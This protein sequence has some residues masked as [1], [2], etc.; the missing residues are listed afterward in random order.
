MTE[1]KMAVK[2]D[3]S[4]LD[5]NL[6]SNDWNIGR[7]TGF[8]S[9]IVLIH[10]YVVD[11]FACL[12]PGIFTLLILYIIFVLTSNI[13]LTTIDYDVSKL[14]KLFLFCKEMTIQFAGFEKIICIIIF[15]YI[16]GFLLYRQDPDKPDKISAYY[17]WLNTPDDTR[18]YSMYD[19]IIKN[20]DHYFRKKYEYHG[21]IF[22]M[23]SAFFGAYYFKKVFDLSREEYNEN[24]IKIE[25]PYMKLK[26]FL[27]KNNNRELADFISWKIGDPIYSLYMTKNFVNKIKIILFSYSNKL[28]N[29][30]CRNEAHVRLCTSLWFSCKYLIYT[31]TFSVLFI[32]LTNFSFLGFVLFSKKYNFSEYWL[33]YIKRI[34]DVSPCIFMLIF[35][36]LLLIFILYKIIQF[37]NYMRIREI[38]YLL[39]A[40]RIAEKQYGYELIKKNPCSTCVTCSNIENNTYC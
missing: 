4:S 19:I 30:I 16:I 22:A 14:N 17:S 40:I 36:F 29:Y 12:I 24:N 5:S 37:L 10:E 13:V 1:E 33:L 35:I 23:M 27:C 18:K 20:N 9:A 39:E 38:I 28:Y 31:F 11:F 15:S 3:D 8:T 7:I 34:F 32:L 25:F 2:A 21:L 26:C 6:S